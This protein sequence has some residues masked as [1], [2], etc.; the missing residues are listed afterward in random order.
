[1]VKLCKKNLKSHDLRH[2]KLIKVFWGMLH[3]QF[4]LTLRQKKTLFFL[5][6]VIEKWSSVLCV[7]LKKFMESR[8]IEMA[9]LLAKK[10]EEGS[11]KKL[12]FCNLSQKKN[13]DNFSTTK[14]VRSCTGFESDDVS[15]SNL[16]WIYWNPLPIPIWRKA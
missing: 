11:A 5:K 14:E 8:I 1:M 4:G 2:D 16:K 6:W 3:S 10:V 9:N 15:H 13:W 12:S 7:K